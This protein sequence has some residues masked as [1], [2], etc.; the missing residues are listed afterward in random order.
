[1]AEL[2]VTGCV[3]HGVGK[4]LRAGAT[5]DECAAHGP[6]GA[7]GAQ[8]ATGG[9]KLLAPDVKPNLGASCSFSKASCTNVQISPNGSIITISEDSDVDNEYSMHT[10]AAGSRRPSA[11][12]TFAQNGPMC[13]AQ[14]QPMPMPMQTMKNLSL[15]DSKLSFEGVES[16]NSNCSSDSGSGGRYFLPAE[17][18]YEVGPP[19]ESPEGMGEQPTTSCRALK[20]EPLSPQARPEP[21]CSCSECF[22][23]G[24][25]AAWSQTRAAAAQYPDFSLYLATPA[26]SSLSGGG[27]GSFLAGRSPASGS[28]TDPLARQDSLLGTPMNLAMPQFSNA[29]CSWPNGAPGSSLKSQSDSS[30]GLS[31]LSAHQLFAAAAAAA[32]PRATA[33]ALSNYLLPGA[34]QQSLSSS[35][36]LLSWQSSASNANRSGFSQYI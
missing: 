20:R 4:R 36:D 9:G 15:A 24:A 6:V 5:S 28:T 16:A 14:E 26:A 18:K 11:R 21:A 1:M 2:D 25:S 10:S 22:M 27:C 17:I 7:A 12:V 33:A 34:F 35:S 31:S 32:D 19:E 30:G 3:S 13:E 29:S 23:Q 8:F